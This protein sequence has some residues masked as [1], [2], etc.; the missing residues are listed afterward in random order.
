M[1]KYNTGYFINIS[2]H[3]ID[4]IQNRS[5]ANLLEKIFKME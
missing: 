4:I 3:Q 5:A 2:S 1:T